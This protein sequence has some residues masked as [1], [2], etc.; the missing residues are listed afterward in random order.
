MRLPI[1]LFGFAV[2]AACAAPRV[3]RAEYRSVLAGVTLGARTFEDRLDLSSEAAVGM[4]FGLGLDR[5]VSLLMDVTYTTPTRE[6]TG[7]L[8][9]VTS[10]RSLVQYRYLAGPV[11]PYLIAGLGGIL[12]DFD[13]TYDAAGGTL[14][15]GC[16]IEVRIARQV[17]LF[18]E[19]SI[20]WYRSRTTSY[21][22]TGEVLDRGA[23]HTDEARTFMAGLQARF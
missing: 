2:L 8:A 15:G 3:A 19:A 9:R 4:R 14:T 1:L 5:H 13:D 10:V 20:D 12:F 7:S 18:G 17:A 11:H 6:T 21:A 22:P 23:R 16:G